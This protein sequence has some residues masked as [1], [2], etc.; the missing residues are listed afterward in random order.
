MKCDAVRIRNAAAAALF[1]LLLPSCGGGS[2]TPPSTLPPATTPPTTQPPATTADPTIKASA[3]RRAG[4]SPLS[5][6][7]DLCAS[8]DANG[9]TNLTYQADFEGEGLTNLS[10][11]GFNHVYKTSGVNVVDTKLCVKDSG[12]RSACTTIT[13]KSYV[14]VDLSVTDNTGCQ[15]TVIATAQL[16]T[17]SFQS[18]G[19]FRIL[20]DVDRVQFEAFNVGGDS[21][22]KKDGSQASTGRWVTG[23]WNV[24]DTQKVRVRA[25]VFSKG[26]A[27]DDTPEGTRPGC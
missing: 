1:A 15:G 2:V 12:G 10:G 24:K 8:R 21:L 23:T 20:G 26:V 11:C 7:F 4:M 14:G 3:D 16:R 22:G 27:G 5:V 25:T 13:I 17:G 18:A 19:G 9:G 6:G